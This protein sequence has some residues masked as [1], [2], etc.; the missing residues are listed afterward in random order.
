M[1]VAQESHQKV[2]AV[3]VMVTRVIV[4]ASLDVAIRKNGSV[5]SDVAVA[6]DDDA[7]AGM[8]VA[9]VLVVVVDVAV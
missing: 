3:V 6:V 7:G 4:A 8:V 5:E 2:T 1:N 9:A